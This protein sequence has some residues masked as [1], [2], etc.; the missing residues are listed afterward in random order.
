[1]NV[2]WQTLFWNTA[3]EVNQWMVDNG[4]AKPNFL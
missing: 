2:I 4:H 3:L 1:M